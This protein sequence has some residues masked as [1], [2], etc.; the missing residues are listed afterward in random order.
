MSRCKNTTPAKKRISCRN[1]T[2]AKMSVKCGK[3]VLPNQLRKCHCGKNV[4]HH[5]SSRVKVFFTKCKT[6]CSL[7]ISKPLCK[8]S[9]IFKKSNVSNPSDSAPLR[10][11]MTPPWEIAPWELVGPPWELKLDP[12]SGNS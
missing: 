9:L 3:N 11:K 7:N 8:R 12:R 6:F 1:V 10:G 5:D 2:V 4:T